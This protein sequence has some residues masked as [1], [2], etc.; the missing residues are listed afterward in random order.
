MTDANLLEQE[1]IVRHQIDEAERC[2]ILLEEAAREIRQRKSNDPLVF[3]CAAG[4]ATEAAREL[5]VTAGMF[6]ALAVLR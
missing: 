5:L 6:E 4:S 1:P 2:A 3:R